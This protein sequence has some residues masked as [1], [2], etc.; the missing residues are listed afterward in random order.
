[1][2]AR[3]RAASARHG[4]ARFDFTSYVETLLQHGLPGLR[5]VSV[6]VPSYQYGRF[7][8]ERLNA[9]FG[10]TYPVLEIVV[11]DDASTD[12]SVHE[13]R[14]AAADAGRDIT[15]EVAARNGG[16]V[17]R[18]WRKA[19]ERARG[20]WVWIAEADDS[21]EPA[22]L[23][24]LCAALDR[25]PAAVMAFTD[26]RAIDAAGQP[27]SDSYIPYCRSTGV[28][29]LARDGIHDG[30]GFVAR[31]LAARNLIL[32]VSSAVFARTALLA[33][34]R[35][36]GDEVERYRVAGDWRLYVDLLSQP[37]AQVAY[38]AAPLNIHRRHA[39]SASGRPDAAHCDEIARLHAVLDAQGV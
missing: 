6:V 2:T 1:R 30:P 33:A 20:D 7:L 5:R 19:A 21:A 27:V 39:G 3:A 10:Q 8:R 28:D 24:S 18:Q 25:A 9:I 13:A 35:R 11:L 23:A 37:G 31:C 14:S 26:S 29:A 16:S 36:I 34:F 38:V 12:D 22:F 4:A 32:N 17:F 15:V